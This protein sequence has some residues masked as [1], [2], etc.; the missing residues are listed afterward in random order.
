M[1]DPHFGQAL[2]SV[3]KRAIEE[4]EE[5]MVEKKTKEDLHCTLFHAHKITEVFW[6]R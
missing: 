4:L 3:M 6:D 5:I 2:R 1:K